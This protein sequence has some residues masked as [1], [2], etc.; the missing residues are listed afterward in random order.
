MTSGNKFKSEFE[1]RPILTTSVNQAKN[2]VTPYRPIKSKR[3]RR[4]SALGKLSNDK[5]LDLL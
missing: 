1:H 3:F 2:Y 5:R 4:S